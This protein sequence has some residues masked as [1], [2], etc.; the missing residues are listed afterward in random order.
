MSNSMK[1]EEPGFKGNTLSAEDVGLPGM[2]LL[3]APSVSMLYDRKF[4]FGLGLLVS[5]GISGSATLKNNAV[6][7]Q[8]TLAAGDSLDSTLDY[9]MFNIEAQYRLPIGL[10]D[11]RFSAGLG[12]ISIQATETLSVNSVD[13]ESQVSQS[14]MPA[15]VGEAAW[16]LRQPTSYWDF[17]ARLLATGS[18]GILMDFELGAAWTFQENHRAGFSYRLHSLTF[19]DKTEDGTADLDLNVMFN[20]PQI[21][22][23]YLF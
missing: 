16:R 12:L 14:I 7:G 18:N 13:Y 11:W 23:S 22:Y 19:S 17:S 15:L 6:V 2:G 21:S 3:I 10:K 1:V 20:G 4:Q 5:P 8:Y 9:M